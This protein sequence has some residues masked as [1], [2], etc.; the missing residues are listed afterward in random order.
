MQ[1]PTDSNLNIAFNVFVWYAASVVC[2]NSSKKIAPYIT[3]L[4]LTLLQLCFA[5]VA[6]Y[7]LI[8][9]VKIAPLQPLDTPRKRN[10]LMVLG[11]C[12][13]LGFST[14]NM[15]LQLM[16]VSNPGRVESGVR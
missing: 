16:H 3:P 11:L 13:A 9:V 14:F 6:S 5:T 15:S 7:L 1:A 10:L 2:T 12:F 8:A 4:N